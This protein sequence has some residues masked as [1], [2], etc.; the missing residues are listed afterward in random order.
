MFALIILTVLQDPFYPETVFVVSFKDIFFLE[1]VM[2]G[3][4]PL[5][6]GLEPL[7]WGSEVNFANNGVWRSEMWGSWPVSP[8]TL[9]TLV[10]SLLV[11]LDN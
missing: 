9:A 10:K 6:W 4:E 1:K 7:V 8:P 2:W 11:S 5:V 3:S